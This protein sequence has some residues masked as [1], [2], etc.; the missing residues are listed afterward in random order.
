MSEKQYPICQQP[1]VSSVSSVPE[2]CLVDAQEL[3]G[4]AALLD[5]LPH[6]NQSFEHSIPFE[7]SLAGTNVSYDFRSFA[8]G[9]EVHV[10]IYAHPADA[11]DEVVSRWA[12]GIDAT[13][14]DQFEI[15]RN[16]D[17][18]PL[19]FHPE[20]SRER[21]GNENIVGDAGAG[22][23]DSR[24]W[25]TIDK[26]SID[27]TKGLNDRHSVENAAAHEFG[28]LMGI[29]DEYGWDP[30]TFRAIT[31]REAEEHEIRAGTAQAADN[32]MGTVGEPMLP[33][34]L[35]HLEEWL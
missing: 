16:G 8:D 23:A 5:E 1:K 31:G 10:P 13:W 30:N 27:P 29:P 12:D 4:N 35:K 20:F 17:R 6:A 7:D 3:Y 19:T 28:H 11:S 22:P 34:H 14:N 21:K 18:F 26:H 32:G 25:Q 33:R 2:Q 9:V 24:Y 15:T